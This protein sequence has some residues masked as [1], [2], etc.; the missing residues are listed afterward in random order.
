MNFIKE[1][2]ERLNDLEDR[3]VWLDRATE[4]SARNVCFIT[5]KTNAKLTR[6]PARP[7]HGFSKQSFGARGKPTQFRDQHNQSRDSPVDSPEHR[8]RTIN[9]PDHADQC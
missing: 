6:Y 9:G 1:S 5:S 2:F 4:L 7:I 8:S 3:L